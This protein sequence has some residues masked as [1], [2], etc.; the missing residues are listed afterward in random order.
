MLGLEVSK[1][2][3]LLLAI[4]AL[5]NIYNV[6]ERCGPKY[7]SIASNKYSELFFLPLRSH[8]Y[9]RFKQKCLAKV[10]F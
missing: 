10:G 4:R 8:V 2:G 6:Q 7:F 3:T 9:Q 1:Y 5:H